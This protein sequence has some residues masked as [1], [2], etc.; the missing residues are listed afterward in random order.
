MRK[1]FELG[2]DG[3]QSSVTA[4]KENELRG[5]QDLEIPSVCLVSPEEGAF[6]SDLR[7]VRFR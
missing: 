2:H 7:G 6:A 1:L 4:D 5:W 3:P